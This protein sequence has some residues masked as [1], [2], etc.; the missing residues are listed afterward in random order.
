MTDIRLLQSGSNR[1]LESGS[2][3]LLEG[4]MPG[5][6]ARSCV[7]AFHRTGPSPVSAHMLITSRLEKLATK[8]SRFPMIYLPGGNGVETSWQSGTSTNPND[9]TDVVRDVVDRGGFHRRACTIPTVW[10]WG[11]DELLG[12][13]DDMISYAETYYGFSGPY[14]LIG[15]S[16]GTVCALNWA[17]FNP[18]R[19]RSVSCMLPACSIQ[20]MVDDGNLAPYY[21]TILPPDDPAA[22]GVRPPDDHNPVSYAT[23]MTGVPTK[24]WYSNNDTICKPTYVT[25]YA[26]S[27]GAA[28][29]NIGNQTGGV[30]PGHGL[31]SGFVATQ[32]GDFVL[33]ND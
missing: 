18:D 31:T 24:L 7:A 15:A 10:T 33:S 26:A 25:Q 23:E 27:S 3:Y 14:H 20:G 13:V 1:L 21:P 6:T 9:V 5:G 29:V 28:T 22:Y 30:L 11:D 32:V 4:A 8:P 19:T 16:M 17:H 2:N 12:W